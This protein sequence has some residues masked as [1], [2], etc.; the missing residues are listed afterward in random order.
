LTLAEA[1]HA[2]Q[3]ASASSIPYATVTVF[4]AGNAGDNASHADHLS[5]LGVQLAKISDTFHLLAD[6]NST[7]HAAIVNE[8]FALQLTSLCSPFSRPLHRSTMPFKRRMKIECVSKFCAPNRLATSI[9][10]VCHVT[11]H[12]V[13]SVCLQVRRA[14]SASE[15]SVQQ[16]CSFGG[17]FLRHGTS[18]RSHT[19]LVSFYRRGVLAVYN[20]C[21]LCQVIQH[22]PLLSIRLQRPAFVLCSGLH[23]GVPRRSIAD[24]FGAFEEAVWSDCLS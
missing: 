9:S 1:L 11:F 21:S 10:H 23:W 16:L 24:Y 22:R 6:L 13:V 12:R 20:A 3:T 15:H 18:P 4:V 14:P 8:W 19:L 2:S 7:L 5:Y 17:R